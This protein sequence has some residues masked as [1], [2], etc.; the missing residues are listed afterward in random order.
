MSGSFFPS[1]SPEFKFKTAKLGYYRGLFA[2]GQ[3]SRAEFGFQFLRYSTCRDIPSTYI[4]PTYLASVNK[5]LT[6]GVQVW[7][8]YRK[9]CCDRAFGDCTLETWPT[10]VWENGWGAPQRNKLTLPTQ[11]QGAITIPA[12][13]KNAHYMSTTPFG[14]LFADEETMLKRKMK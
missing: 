10:G 9:S 2:R 5:N 12:L 13:L 14:S 11:I 1:L 3:S 4:P 8:C 7:L 6:Q